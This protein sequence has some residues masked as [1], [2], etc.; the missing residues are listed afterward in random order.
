MC[1]PFS[2]HKR[3]RSIHAYIL[4]AVIWIISIAISII[5]MDFTGKYNQ[6]TRSAEFLQEGI[7][8]YTSFY[9]YSM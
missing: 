9:Q 4:I 2:Y 1:R 8:K 7:I 3:V 5:P 6:D